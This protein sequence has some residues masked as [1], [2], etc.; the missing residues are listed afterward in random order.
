M[1]ADETSVDSVLSSISSTNVLSKFL[2]VLSATGAAAEYVTG[3][4]AGEG[5]G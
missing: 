2:F 4:G 5:S 1:G 3:A